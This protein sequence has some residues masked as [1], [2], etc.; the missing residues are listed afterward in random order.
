MPPGTIFYIGQLPK[1]FS[2]ETNL[3]RAHAENWLDLS[4]EAAARVDE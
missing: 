1:Q 4:Y 3:N 2:A